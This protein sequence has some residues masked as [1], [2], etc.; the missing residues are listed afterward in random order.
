MKHKKFMDIERLKTNYADGFQKG[1]I[2]HISEKIDGAN[3]AIRYDSETDTIVAQS[4]KNI[5]SL[6]NN[7]RGFWNWTQ[8]LNKGLVKSV[9][10]DDKVL[11]MEWLVPHSVKYLENRYNHAYC[12]D[13]FDTETGCYLPQNKVKE[14][15]DALGLTYVPVFYEGEF[16]SWEHCQS[17]VG[18]TEL[19]GEYGE[20]IV[21]KNQT[22]LND[23]NTRLP[24]YV[25]IVGEKFQE[26]KGHKH[27]KKAVSPEA[28][29]KKEENQ[30]LAETIVT[31]ARVQ[32]ILNKFIDEGILPEDW[33]N[34]EMPIIAKNLTKAIYADCIKE[35][36]GIVQQVND[37]GKV[38]NGICMRIARRIME[39][40]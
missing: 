28:L 18:R 24:F 2:I 5:L 25:K 17:F 40:R 34:K 32:K 15:V 22:R 27:D 8:T 26:T 37:F 35:E 10:G 19:G 13:V 30:A 7:L 39:S 33:G 1:D 9:L 23:Q 31:E 20:G 16:I 21:V 4:R 12:Y 11:F 36:E 14:I 6:E 38:A 29:K 3:A